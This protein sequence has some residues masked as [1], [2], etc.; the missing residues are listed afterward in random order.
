VVCV[1]PARVCLCVLPL[2]VRMMTP[3]TFVMPGPGS[4][5]PPYH[6]SFLKSGPQ[7]HTGGGTSK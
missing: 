7:I 4:D 6:L 3:L 5:D 1:L 2:G